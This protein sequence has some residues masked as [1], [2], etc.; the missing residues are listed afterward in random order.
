MYKY[1]S[2]FQYER[3][4]MVQEKLYQRGINLSFRMY[5]GEVVFNQFIIF[6]LELLS[7]GTMFYELKSRC[8]TNDNMYS[9]MNPEDAGFSLV[10][11][12][13]FKNVNLLSKVKRKLD[14]EKILSPNLK[15]I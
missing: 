9:L 10:T 13:T 4:S 11:H 7:N 5:K 2:I 14:F 8:N 15:N 6:R 1:N 3:N 12:K